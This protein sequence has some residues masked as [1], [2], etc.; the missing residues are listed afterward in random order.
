MPSDGTG[1]VDGRERKKRSSKRLSLWP[2][3]LEE[4]VRAVV[5]AGPPPKK[6]KTPKT[7]RPSENG[8][9]PGRKPDTTANP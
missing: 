8:E 1:P 6:A 4:A 2:L 9:K 3:T 7:A 5:Q